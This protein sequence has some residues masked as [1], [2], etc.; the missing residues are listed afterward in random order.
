MPKNTVTKTVGTS[1]RPWNNGHF[2]SLNSGALT[3]TTITGSSTLAIDTDVLKVDVANDRV[4]V[5]QG[6]PLATLQMKSIGFEYI[7]G[8]GVLSSSLATNVVVF[9]KTQFRS[10]KIMVELVNSTDSRYET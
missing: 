5:K 9:N 1:A 3:A 10:A 2:T 6:T 8:S 4:G 7:S